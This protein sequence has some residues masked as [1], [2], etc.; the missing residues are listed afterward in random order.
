MFNLRRVFL[1]KT[2]MALGA[3][4]ALGN[5]A[6]SVNPAA[7]RDHPDHPAIA[8]RIWSSMNPCAAANPCAATNA[9]AAKNPCAASNPCAATNPCAA[10]NPCAAG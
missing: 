9:C 4:V 8:E 3:A 5:I 1:K 10:E 6:V 7:A 2:L